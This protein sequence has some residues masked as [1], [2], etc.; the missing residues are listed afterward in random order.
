MG[1]AELITKAKNFL[2]RDIRIFNAGEQAVTPTL[3]FIPNWFWTAQLGM[4]RRTNIL[5]IRQYAKSGWVQMVTSSI[6]KQAS[7]TEWDIITKDDEMDAKDFSEEIEKIK[8]FLKQPNRNGDTFWDVWGPAL[9]D[10]LE[11]DAGVVFKGRNLAGE[12]KELFVY[13]GS[14]FLINIDQHGIINEEMGY[15]QYSFMF[16]TSKPRPFRKDEIVYLQMKKSTEFYPYGFSPLQGIQQEVELLIQS[17]RWNKEFFKNNAMPDGMVTVPMEFEK[18]ERFKDSWD[19]QV[20]GKPHKLVFHNSAGATFTPF[21]MNNKDMEWLDGQKWFFHIVFGAWGLS[22]QEVGF[23]ENSNKSTSESQERITVKN[24][25][26]PYLEMILRKI[27]LEI[28]P[29]LVGHDNLK[30]IW[31]LT[32]EQ[33][34][35]LEHQQ[36]MEKLNAG[37]IT[38]NEFRGMEG[39]EDVEW[40]DQPLNLFMQERFKSQVVEQPG[41]KKDEEEEDKKQPG[42]RDDD[43]ERPDRELERARGLYTKLFTKFVQTKEVTIE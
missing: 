28:I 5:E 17:T 19:Q 24:A 39:K 8:T 1:I 37:V 36:L 26:K 33:K 29:E 32:D 16:P 10:V 21:N 6:L 38:I 12:L 4:P 43:T 9:L 3:P 14:R 25:I 31:Y 7:T 13:D 15:F 34:E 22:P 23:F 11:I 41:G 2:A 20:K 18:M 35:K 42:E 30:F 27:N 40:G